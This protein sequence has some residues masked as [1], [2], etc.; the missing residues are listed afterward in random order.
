MP[1]SQWFLWEILFLI[2]LGLSC[3]QHH[4]ILETT[5]IVQN[6]FWG[7]YVAEWVRGE[8]QEKSAHRR[9]VPTCVSDAGQCL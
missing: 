5:L 1:P 4:L 9:E 3:L 8:Q 7:T 2:F 6:M